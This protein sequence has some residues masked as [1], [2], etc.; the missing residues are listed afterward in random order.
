MQDDSLPDRGR[1]RQQRPPAEPKRTRELHAFG[2]A[3]RELR[4]RRDFSQEELGDLPPSRR[5]VR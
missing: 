2:R 3:V 5:L 1:Q 4:A